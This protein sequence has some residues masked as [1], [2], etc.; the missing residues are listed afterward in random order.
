MDAITIAAYLVFQV[1]FGVASYHYAAVMRAHPE[2]LSSLDYRMWRDRGP[3]SLAL[4][5]SLFVARLVGIAFVLF[6]WYKTDWLQAAVI[7]GAGL[8]LSAVLGPTI[9]KFGGGTLATAICMVIIPVT[10]VSMWFL[11]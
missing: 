7:F 6:V 10:G 1:F 4:T 2:D 9:R 3:L 11:V 8:V 5:T